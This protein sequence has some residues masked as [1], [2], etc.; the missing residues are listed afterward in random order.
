MTDVPRF[1]DPELPAA[2]PLRVFVY[3]TLKPGGM[4]YRQVCEA[5][6]PQ[7]IPAWI[8][9]RLYHLPKLNYPAVTTGEDRIQGFVLSFDA[10]GPLAE[11]DEVEEYDAERPESSL[12]LRHWLTIQTDQGPVEAWGYLMRHEQ[13]Q[14]LG[15]IYLPE[16]LWDHLA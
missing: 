10:P 3:G 12:Y 15:G 4:Y 1:V 14:A 5:F 2:E 11:L 6:A 8:P 9:G 7:A 13:V 16:G